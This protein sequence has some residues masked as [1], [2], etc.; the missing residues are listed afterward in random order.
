[1]EWRP[2]GRQ[3]EETRQQVA[4]IR[5]MLAAGLTSMPTTGHRLTWFVLRD[6][7][8]ANLVNRRRNPKTSHTT[9]QSDDDSDEE[10]AMGD[11]GGGGSSKAIAQTGVLNQWQ[12]GRQAAAAI[13][14]TLK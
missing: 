9:R 4:Q 10:D 12:R 3:R 6:L 2:C 14:R 13:P 1:M 5:E 8:E 7:P 11:K